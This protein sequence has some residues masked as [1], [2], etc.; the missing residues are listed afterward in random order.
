MKQF[1]YELIV[2]ILY[3]IFVIEVIKMIGFKDLTTSLFTLTIIFSLPMVYL[4]VKTARLTYYE[5][6]R[7][8]WE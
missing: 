4:G 1:K 7:L 6:K 8:K 2:T 3:N 5:L